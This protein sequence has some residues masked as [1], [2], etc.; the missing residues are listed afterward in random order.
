LLSAGVRSHLPGFSL[1]VYCDASVDPRA[2]RA[3]VLPGGERDASLDSIARA[4]EEAFVTVIADGGELV[5]YQCDAA[6]VESGLGHK[7]L[8]G[9]LLRFI[10]LFSR[11]SFSAADAALAS[12]IPLSSSSSIPSTFELPEWCGGPVD[13]NIVFVCD[14]DFADFTLEHLHLHLVSWF[15]RVSEMSDLAPA[16]PV[17]ASDFQRVRAPPPPE[18]VCFTTSG[19]AAPRHSPSC[20]LPPFIANCI[21]TSAR[22]PLSWLRDF[23][24][25]VLNG[26]SSSSVLRRFVEDMHSPRNHNFA[27]EKRRVAEQ[28][29]FPYGIDE[30]FLTNVLKP[31]AISRPGKEIFQQWLFFVVPSVDIIVR[32]SLTLCI[33]AIKAS[34]ASGAV[35]A[36]P[37]SNRALVVRLLSAASKCAGNDVLPPLSAPDSSLEAQVKRWENDWPARAAARVSLWERGCPARGPFS[38]AVAEALASSLRDVCAAQVDALAAGALPSRGVEELEYVLQNSEYLGALS[39][40]LAG[41]LAFVVGGGRS[42]FLGKSTPHAQALLRELQSTSGMCCAVQHPRS[43]KLAADIAAYSKALALPRGMLHSS[44]LDHPQQQKQQQ[45]SHSHVDAQDQS[46]SLN[47]HLLDAQLTRDELAGFWSVLGSSPML[48]KALRGAIVR[49]TIASR[50]ASV[51]RADASAPESGRLLIVLGAAPQQPQELPPASAAPQQLLLH[52]FD[53]QLGVEQR[54]PV[55]NCSNVR[56]VPREADAL[57]AALAQA[58]TAWRR[59][60]HAPDAPPVL[61]T[62]SDVARV[63]ATRRRIVEDVEGGC[64]CLA[65]PSLL[66]A[67]NAEAQP[68]GTPGAG[69]SVLL[70]LR[71]WLVQDALARD[72]HSLVHDAPRSF[73]Y[74]LVHRVREHDAAEGAGALFPLHIAA[75]WSHD[76]LQPD[77]TAWR[78]VRRSI[79]ASIPLEL[80]RQAIVTQV[81]YA[82]AIFAPPAAA[83]LTPSGHRARRLASGTQLFVVDVDIIARQQVQEQKA[84]A[85]NDVPQFDADDTDAGAKRWLLCK[86][87]REPSGGS[88]IANEC[89][90]AMVVATQRAHAERRKRPRDEEEAESATSTVA[91]GPLFYRDEAPPADLGVFGAEVSVVLT[92]RF[93]LGFAFV[94]EVQLERAISAGAPAPTAPHV[95][96]AWPNLD[97]LKVVGTAR[98]LLCRCL[99]TNAAPLQSPPPD[100]G[101]ISEA[102]YAAQMT[103]PLRLPST[104]FWA[105][106]QRFSPPLPSPG[107]PPQS[108]PSPHGPEWIPQ[109]FPRRNGND[110]HIVELFHGT[111]LA[112]AS[113]IAGRGFHRV[114]CRLTGACAERPSCQCN[115]LGS[116]VYLSDRAKAE[117]ISLQ[118]GVFDAK[119]NATVAAV[120]RVRVDLGLLKVAAAHPPCSCG[121]G[122][123]FADH[124]GVFHTVQGF[125]SLF[126]RDNSFGAVQQREWIVA[127][128]T[129]CFVIGVEEVMKAADA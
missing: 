36:A 52:V 65:P 49:V 68:W 127:D 120:I 4:W 87:V 110:S 71:S 56:A 96:G 78:A 84:R 73:G 126:V 5:W 64:G 60:G 33:E 74:L 26:P 11:S 6:K 27:F 77:V 8:F 2:I 75:S 116:G 40:F 1:R 48:D 50:T 105:L 45:A 44:A 91:P 61:L 19:S 16:G 124:H 123:P 54:V 14:A 117:H 47:A 93:Q 118:F 17:S 23:L 113:A 92:R 86:L 29:S 62:P 55:A 37:A 9:T 106:Y 51:R 39:P 95:A 112:M 90:K 114:Q 38:S 66:A 72:A 20:G 85:D 57:A 7:D 15:A 30:F 10:P 21:A 35:N 108:S 125:D 101:L 115:L 83:V 28:L 88:G 34:S 121:C 99:G 24:R 53:A 98:S 102:L 104:H 97:G 111:S 109:L 42:I 41:A 70:V 80:F 119:R 107:D 58:N 46:S 82:E 122:M 100:P 94:S 22:F 18:L 76:E 31:R 81:D 63:A 79:D 59:L 13:N 67:L 43:S 3:Q 128:P 32:K 129:R 25:D 69:H 89:V 12:S 103:T